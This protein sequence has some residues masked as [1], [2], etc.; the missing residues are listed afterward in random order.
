MEVRKFLA[1]VKELARKYNVNFFIVTDGASMIDN[2]GSEAVENCR[3]A[4]IKWELEH[5]LNPW[6]DFDGQEP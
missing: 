3:Q 5:G 6:E 2:N 1:E 4:H